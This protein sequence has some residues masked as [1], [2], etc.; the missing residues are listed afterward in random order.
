MLNY[1]SVLRFIFG[2]NSGFVG[3][4]IP[5]RAFCCFTS[6]EC[7]YSPFFG[8]VQNTH[9]TG[10]VIYVHVNIIRMSPH[11]QTNTWEVAQLKCESQLFHPVL[12]HSK[13]K[14][15]NSIILSWLISHYIYYSLIHLKFVSCPSIFPLKFPLKTQ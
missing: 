5:G 12:P 15:S 6:L 14:F 11:A 8:L 7:P 4:V 10:L 2:S 13:S 3:L 1:Q 9:L